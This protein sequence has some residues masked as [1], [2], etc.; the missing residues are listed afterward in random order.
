MREKQV[1]PVVVLGLIAALVSVVSLWTLERAEAPSAGVAASVATGEVIE[2]KLVT[3]WPKGLP[4]L[5]AAPENFARRVNE[6]SGGRLR[7]KVFGAGEIVPA[8]E[9]FD[10]V[11]RGVAEAGHGASYYWKG[12]IP[13]SVFYTAVPFGM[14]AQEANGWLHYG[15]GLEL[16]REL[17]APFGV[18]PFAGGSTGVQMAGWFNI[19]LNSRADLDGLKMRIPGLAGEVF[20]AA[21]GSAV[22]IAGGEVYTSMQ[23]G[24]IDAVEWVGPYNDR[25]L[26]LMEVGDYYYY[27]GWHEPGAMLETIVNAEALAA[28]PDDLQAIV[29]VAARATNTDMLDD[30]TANN[31]ESLQILLNEFETEVLPLPD[32]VMDALYENSQVAIQ[33]LVEADPM[34]KKIAASYFEFA[35]KVRT[36]HEI[37][38]RAYLNGRNRLLPPVSLTAESAE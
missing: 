36:Y 17:Y 7:I 21:G 19:R 15:G 30:F 22:R 38:E 14:T 13:A 31:S 6:A 5:G 25:T 9:V 16:W 32:D 24:V 37:S 10:A 11:S 20:D 3:T 2:W 27:P 4:G 34:A 12:K 29:R 28:L 8:F 1:L 18:V 26:G 33:A 23:T 35:D